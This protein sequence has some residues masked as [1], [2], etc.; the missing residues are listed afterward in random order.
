MVRGWNAKKTPILEA[1][2]YELFLSLMMDQKNW[3]PLFKTE[4]YYKNKKQKQ[5]KQ[6]QPKK[7]KTKKPEQVRAIY[8]WGRDSSMKK[9]P[10]L[11][12]MQELVK[13]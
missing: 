4:S 11:A 3:D 1:Q 9:D 13:R 12:H 5:T 8:S 6:E 10:L 7:K 2:A